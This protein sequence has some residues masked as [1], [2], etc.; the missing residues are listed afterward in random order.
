MAMK[1][2]TVILGLGSNLE[3]RLAHLR[4]ALQLIKKIPQLLVKQASPLYKSDA[5]LPENAPASWNIPYFNLAL[6]CET[7]LSPN[8]ILDHV[9]KIELMIGRQPEKR[10][11][12]ACH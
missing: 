2:S 6:R 1:N 12:A 4:C 3:N 7:S 8:E 5:L 9:K 10:W 11:G